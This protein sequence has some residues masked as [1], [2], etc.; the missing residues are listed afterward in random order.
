MNGP[1]FA[2]SIFSVKLSVNLPSPKT[3]TYKRYNKSLLWFLRSYLYIILLATER[4]IF[5]QRVTLIVSSL[6]SGIVYLG[7][8]KWNM[9]FWDDAYLI[10]ETMLMLRSILMC[11]VVFAIDANENPIKNI[12]CTKTNQ[13]NTKR[14]SLCDFLLYVVTCYLLQVQKQ[15]DC[16][17]FD[18]FWYVTEEEYKFSWIISV[19]DRFQEKAFKKYGFAR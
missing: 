14:M 2:L 15:E 16:Y 13:F 19:F 10:I 17:L 3:N 5:S 7:Y 11:K 1:I 9:T 12:K 6:I 4:I 18:W 8:V